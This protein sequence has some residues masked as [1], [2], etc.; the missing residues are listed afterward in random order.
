M[1]GLLRAFFFRLFACARSLIRQCDGPHTIMWGLSRN[2]RLPT[3]RS[4]FV[5]VLHAQCS[6]ATAIAERLLYWPK[7]LPNHFEASGFWRGTSDI[8]TP[9]TT[10]I[11]FM[12][13][14][15]E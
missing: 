15:V 2:P 13:A 5:A 9:T 8:F 14:L 10:P 6:S 1:L 12:G 3:R 4:K 11:L 7:L